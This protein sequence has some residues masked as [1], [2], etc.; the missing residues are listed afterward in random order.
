MVRKGSQS[1]VAEGALDVAVPLPASVTACVNCA[2]HRKNPG[3]RLPG[4]IRC[5][6]FHLEADHVVNTYPWHRPGEGARK[7]RRCSAGGA[8]FGAARREAW[9]EVEIGGA[10]K[11]GM[12]AKGA[13]GVDRGGG[14]GAE[15]GV[16]TLAAVTRAQ[17]TDWST[18]RARA[19]LCGEASLHASMEAC[20]ASD[21]GLRF[22]LPLSMGGSAV[23]SDGTSRATRA[24]DALVGP[25]ECFGEVLINRQ[26][27][28]LDRIPYASVRAGDARLRE[29]VKVA[30]LVCQNADVCHSCVLRADRQ[31]FDVLV[32]A[33]HRRASGPIQPLR[34]PAWQRTPEEEDR[35]KRERRGL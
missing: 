7:S 16:L 35:V 31:G 13:P 29:V 22:H 24:A 25:T 34:L 8:V 28:A 12:T 10:R 20:A 14:W 9:E 21:P 30:A 5:D 32:A 15:F 18:A 33:F 1:W 11:K 17:A 3:T 2:W 27:I 4:E 6:E 19:R 26:E 23:R